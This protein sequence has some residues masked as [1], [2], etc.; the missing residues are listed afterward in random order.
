MNESADSPHPHSN[1]IR[2]PNLTEERKSIP[3]ANRH[4][5][6]NK[7]T[8]AKAQ[9]ERM[10][11]LDHQYRELKGSLEKGNTKK[12]SEEL[13]IPV[14]TK[15]LSRIQ[16]KSDI[17]EKEEVKKTNEKLNRA[18]EIELKRRKVLK[19]T[20]ERKISELKNRVSALERE[21]ESKDRELVDINNQIAEAQS[22]L[23][24]VSSKANGMHN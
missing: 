3:Q 14:T 8:T 24:S 13:F 20:Y 1:N 15:S 11:L 19:Q 10:L 21:N 6:E 17:K 12:L 22:R 4:S 7:S 18:K 2:L 16:N 9:F 5:V 23:S